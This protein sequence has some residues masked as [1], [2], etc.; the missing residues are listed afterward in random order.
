MQMK[1]KI[2]YTQGPL[3]GVAQLFRSALYKVQCC[4][5][6][7]ACCQAPDNPREKL[8]MVPHWRRSAW[9]ISSWR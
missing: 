5:S 1:Q 6:M 8:S 2:I 7:T 9:K 3:S 4:H